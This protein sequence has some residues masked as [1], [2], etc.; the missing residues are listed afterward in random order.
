MLTHLKN[1]DNSI[2]LQLQLLNLLVKAIDSSAQQASLQRCEAL[3]ECGMAAPQS[4]SHN[5]RPSF[6]TLW[7]Q[8]E[9]TLETLRQVYRTSVLTVASGKLVGT[10]EASASSQQRP[11]KPAACPVDTRSLLFIV[12]E[13]FAGRLDGDREHVVIGDEAGPRQGQLGAKDVFLERAL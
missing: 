11:Q 3:A 2:N 12:G 9:Q 7:L 6:G 5:R 8:F 10:G 1:D 13:Y 4:V